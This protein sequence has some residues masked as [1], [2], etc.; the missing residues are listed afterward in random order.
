M[1]LQYLRGEITLVLRDLH[2]NTLQAF[3]HQWTNPRGPRCHL[4][5]KWTER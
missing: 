5:E 1:E 2:V 3:T 4:E